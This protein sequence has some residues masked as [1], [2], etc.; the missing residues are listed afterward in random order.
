MF[1]FLGLFIFGWLLVFL[2]LPLIILTL[3]LFMFVINAVL[4]YIT[5]KIIEDFEIQNFGATI[6]AAF[7]ITISHSF[8]KW[9]F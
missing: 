4:L 7:L 1:L 2:T 9:V 8:L 6:I 3:E 5:D